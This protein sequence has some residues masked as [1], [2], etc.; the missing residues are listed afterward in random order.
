M[1][2]VIPEACCRENGR[3][4]DIF[5]ST[6]QYCT[7]RPVFSDLGHQSRRISSFT[8][9]PINFLACLEAENDRVYWRFAT[10]VD[11]DTINL[12]GSELLVMYSHVF[13]VHNKAVEIL[14][15]YI[16]SIRLWIKSCCKDQ[17]IT[18]DN[19]FRIC[20]P[21]ITCFF[22]NVSKDMRYCSG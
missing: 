1:K 12:L 4:E 5:P 6:N 8:N 15:G 21:N 7:M 20:D 2:E 16:R 10:S 17:F 14:S 9:H 18:G 11:S 3:R 19:L 22:V 13:G